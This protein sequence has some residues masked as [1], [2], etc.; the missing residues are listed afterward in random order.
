MCHPSSHYYLHETF[1]GS[2]SD[3]FTLQVF[4]FLGTRFFPYFRRGIII[5]EIISSP[6]YNKN[7][8]NCKLITQI[9]LAPNDDF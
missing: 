4:T 3:T 2:F 6:I 8:C 1:E 5:V 9:I 7:C